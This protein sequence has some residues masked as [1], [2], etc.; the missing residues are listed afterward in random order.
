MRQ[1]ILSPRDDPIDGHERHHQQHHH[2]RQ[3]RGIAQP[4]AEPQIPYLDK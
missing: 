4:T 3:S 1:E 2:E